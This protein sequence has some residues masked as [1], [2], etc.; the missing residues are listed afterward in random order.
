MV[1][2]MGVCAHGSKEEDEKLRC[3]LHQLLPHRG[4]GLGKVEV[5]DLSIVPTQESG[6]FRADG[7]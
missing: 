4:G 7:K 5:E 6:I 2:Q 1:F 3:R